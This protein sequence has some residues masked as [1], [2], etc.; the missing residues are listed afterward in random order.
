M[1]QVLQGEQWLKKPFLLA[2]CIEPVLINILM[3]TDPWHNLFFGGK[4]ELNTASILDAGV[5]SWANIIYSYFLI[6]VAFVLLA[7]AVIRSKGLYRR[8]Y[9]TIF[10]RNGHHLDRQLDFHAGL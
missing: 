7:R 10:G 4:R 5:A 3:W 1:I 6:A 8:Q 2:L 9:L